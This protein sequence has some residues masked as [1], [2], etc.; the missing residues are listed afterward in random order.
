MSSQ[1]LKGDQP[2]VDALVSTTCI[3]QC[4]VNLVIRVSDG[5]VFGR[6][7]EILASM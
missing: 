4:A 5:M 1:T 6:K 7:E 2:I 3:V